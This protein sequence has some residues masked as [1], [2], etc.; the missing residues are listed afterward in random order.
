[1]DTQQPA[2]NRA[3]GL[4][5]ISVHR[6]IHRLTAL[7]KSSIQETEGDKEEGADDGA[8]YS[9]QAAKHAGMEQQVQ[10]VR[11][12]SPSRCACLEFVSLRGLSLISH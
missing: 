7:G 9:D 5:T 12:L 3:G 1:M 11:Q 6:Q 10:Q 4:G 8:R 2:T